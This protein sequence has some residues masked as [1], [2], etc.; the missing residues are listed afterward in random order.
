MSLAKRAARRIEWYHAGY[1]PLSGSPGPPH[2]EF[3]A[4]AYG[5]HSTLVDNPQLDYFAYPI[6]T[7]SDVEILACSTPTQVF[8]HGKLDC[9][10]M[11]QLVS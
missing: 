8:G 1:P 5:L 3:V 6:Q 4:D 11:K 7:T 10:P 9:T 2:N